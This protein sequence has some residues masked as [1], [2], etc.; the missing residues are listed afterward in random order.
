MTIRKLSYSIL[1]GLIIIAGCEKKPFDYRNKYIGDWEF[2]VERTEFNIDSVGHYK[3]DSLTYLGEITYGGSG[4]EIIIN[5]TYNNSIALTIDKEGVLSD[6]PTHYCS[7]KFDGDD[8][9][10]IFLRW[11]GLGGGISH[12]IDGEKKRH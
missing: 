1:F 9:I 3:H 5:Y 8:K 2:N 4:D 7:G 10:H 6:F 12:R 11:G